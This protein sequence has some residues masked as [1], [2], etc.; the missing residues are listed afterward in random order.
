MFRRRWLISFV[1]P[2]ALLSQQ[3]TV[4]PEDRKRFE[5]I[6]ARHDKGEPISDEDRAFAMRIM[7]SL[8]GQANQ[9]ANQQRNAEYA[10]S[11][12]PH[13]SVGFTPLTELGTGRY[14]GE[15]GGLYPVGS[16]TPPPAH[17]AN[18]VKLAHEIVPL[19]ADGKPSPDGKIVLLTTGM[20]NTT[21]ESQAFIKLAAGDPQINPHVLLLDGAQG[22]QTAKVIAKPDANYWKEDDRRLAAAGVTAKQVQAVW[23]KQANAGPT[24]PFPTEAKRLEED[25]RAD[26]KILSDRFP[27]LKQVFLSSRIYAGYAST[28]LNPEPHAY[29]TAFADKWLIAEQ[30]AGKSDLRPWLAWGPYLWADGMKPRKDGL[31]WT[32]ED[33]GPDGTHPSELGRAKVAKLLLDFFK[34]S[35][36]TRPWFVKP[37]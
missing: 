28:P 15:E 3:Q 12:P 16:N 21:M 29:E 22:G 19:D 5:E 25:I 20:S 9:Q 34:S 37:M 8:N 36:A 18:G 27:N 26:I 1:L 32:R 30:I 24:E 13:D 4:S 2:L 35:P 17:L 6:K 14:K 33:L 7:R 23:L 31:V 11:H 10:K